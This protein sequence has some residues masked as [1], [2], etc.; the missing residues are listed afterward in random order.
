MSVPPV[1]S[2]A[3]LQECGR[4]RLTLLLNIIGTPC[5]CI[6]APRDL[7]DLHYAHEVA[8]ASAD[9][10][11]PCL[12]RCILGRAIEDTSDQVR[13]HPFAYCHLHRTCPQPMSRMMTL[14]KSLDKLEDRTH[15]G[16][17]TGERLFRPPSWT[18]RRFVQCI[19]PAHAFRFDVQM[20]HQDLGSCTVVR[21]W[22]MSN[23][24]AGL[25]D[26]KAQICFVSSS[27]LIRP[28]PFLS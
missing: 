13:I 26:S 3:R 16:Q 17:A 14:H 11:R 28:L 9:T 21:E 27:S 10:K 20:Q 4:I 19:K 5:T 18:V 12:C 23:V 24:E 1:S 25:I 2:L 15:N 22:G 6:W 7:K 8:W